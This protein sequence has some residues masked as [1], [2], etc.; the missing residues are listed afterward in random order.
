[1]IVFKDVLQVD[2]AEAVAVKAWA[3]EALAAAARRRS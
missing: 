2:D 1:M 3:I